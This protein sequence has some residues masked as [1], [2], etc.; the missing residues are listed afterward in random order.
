MFGD[1]RKKLNSVIQ[2]G[3][4]NLSNTYI[5]TT[6]LNESSSRQSVDTSPL[7]NPLLNINFEA[8]CKY[9][10]LRESQWKEIHQMNEDNAALADG[11]DENIKAMKDTSTRVLTEVN[12]FNIMLTS[13]PTVSQTLRLCAEMAAEL[14]KNCKKVEKELVVLEDIQD[15]L[16]LEAAKRKHH[17]EMAVYKEKKL[18]ELEKVRQ[19]LL[20]VHV[21]NVQDYEKKLGEIQKERQ[22]VFQDAFQ[23]DLEDYKTLGKIPKVESIK[24]RPELTLEEISLDNRD[25]EALDNFLNN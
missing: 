23:N 9:L 6:S 16:D 18:V 17:L 10:E 14:G 12:D 1:F 8:G 13:L 25:T 4:E 19:K 24:P 20:D 3:R 2:E 11:I 7:S 21:N 15:R 5:R 22:A